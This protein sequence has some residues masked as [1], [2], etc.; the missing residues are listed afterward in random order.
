LNF[1]VSVICPA[2]NEKENIP[3][4]FKELKEKLSE[5]YEIILVDDGS[6][7]GTYETALVEASKYNNIKVI[8]HLKNYGKTE[9][10]IS[11]LKA[12]SGEII[13]IYDA[14]RQFL[15]EDV[16]KIVKK[17]EEGYDLVCGYKVG[18]YEKKLV[19]KI[20]NFLARLLFRIP[21]RDINAL[22]GMRKEV[23]ENMKLRKDWHRYIVP[24]AFHLGYKITE[25]P[26]ILRKREYGLPKYSSKKRII[27]GFFD[28]LAVAFQ[29]TF[30]KKPMLYFGTIGLV[31]L[32]FGFLVGILSI[33]L[34][35][36]GH[37]YRPLLYLV[38]LLIL[39]GIL[40]FS[41]GLIGEVQTSIIERLEDIERKLK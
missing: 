32:T 19:S 3:F 29:L 31:S 23:L 12:S 2:Y 22:K 13:V 14:D 10:I 37:G 41:L 21:V 28:L 39:S 4:L 35:L 18:K 1:K 15:P 25:I 8:K 20:Y 7:D 16:V 34:R 17:I 38:I 5:D 26:V 11:G 6:N 9:A 30:L 24:L 40:F 27:I 36:F 33:I